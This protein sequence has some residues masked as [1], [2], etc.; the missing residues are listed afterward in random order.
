M[1]RR[2]GYG[3]NLSSFVGFFVSEILDQWCDSNLLPL[4]ALSVSLKLRRYWLCNG[5]REAFQEI[6]KLR[7]LVDRALTTVFTYPATWDPAVGSKFD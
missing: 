5:V 4:L 6:Y 7:I 2:L 3:R 1:F